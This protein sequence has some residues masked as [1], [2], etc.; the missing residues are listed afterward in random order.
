MEARVEDGALVVERL[1]VEPGRALD[2]DALT[3]ALERHARACG[4]EVVRRARAAKR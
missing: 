4:V 2:E 1:W 3:E